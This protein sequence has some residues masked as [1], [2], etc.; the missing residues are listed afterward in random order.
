VAEKAGFIPCMLYLI[1]LLFPISGCTNL[2][3]TYA[4]IQVIKDMREKDET[5]MGGERETFL[6]THWSLI[7]DVQSREDKDHALI[8]LLLDKYWKPVYCYLRRKGYSNEEAK[9]LTQGF[10][11]EVVLSRE[12]VRRADQSRGR[13][14]SFLLHALNQYLIDEKRRQTSLKR[15]PR[16]KLVPLDFTDPPVLPHIISMQAPEECF[17]YAWKS[18]LLDQSLSQVHEKCSEQGMETHWHVF[19][20]KVVKP[21]LDDVKPLSLNEICAKYNIENETRASNMIVTVKRRFQAAL[22][23]NV[24]NTV[25]SEDQIDEELR[26]ILKFFPKGAQD[27]KNPPD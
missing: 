11:H 2:V 19:R 15:I 12:L 17:N 5:D 7:E 10:F 1:T 24:R 22:K 13:F 23:K 27:S 14:R 20:E 18:T 6:T 9:D 16:D 8:G 4:Y 21:I 3:T 26:E 25:I